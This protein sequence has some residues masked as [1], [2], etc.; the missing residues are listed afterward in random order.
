[1]AETVPPAV[2]PSRLLQLHR[3]VRNIIYQYT[4]ANS[5]AFTEL[6]DEGHSESGTL[7]TMLL[8]GYHPTRHVSLLRCNSP[9]FTTKRNPCSTRQYI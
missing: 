6:F 2:E 3:E 5:G 8:G 1:M 7:T 4:F 9:R